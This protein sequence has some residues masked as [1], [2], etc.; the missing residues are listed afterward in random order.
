MP[1]G[2][3]AW[4]SDRTLKRP[5]RRDAPTAS[6]PQSHLWPRVPL[7]RVQEAAV[8][9]WLPTR[10]WL[11]AL[12]VA[13]LLRSLTPAASG[14]AAALLRERV[15][16]ALQRSILQQAVALPLA[17]FERSEVYA[18]LDA[19]RIALQ[20]PVVDVLWDLNMLA[21]SLI[22][23]AGLL[24]LALRGTIDIG[25]LVA[26]LDGISRYRSL[27]WII[28]G[29][30]GR[31]VE[32]WAPVTYLR[33]FLALP[34]GNEGAGAAA[35]HEVNAQQ[36]D[37]ANAQRGH[38]TGWEE[39]IKAGG[40]MPPKLRQVVSCR[41]LSFTY[42]GADRP[43]LANVNLTFGAGE[44]VALVGENGAGKTTLVKVLLG[45][46]QP[47]EGHI[48][49]D[50]IDLSTLDPAVWRRQATAI[51]QD[52]VHYPTTALE[53]IAYA[54]VALLASEQ[55][56]EQAVPV[57]VAAAARQSGADAVIAALTSARSP[58]GRWR[59]AASAT[60]N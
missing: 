9:P 44:H 11:A 27:A 55:F 15:N 5:A 13:T 3:A 1:R 2:S 20:N 28:S 26:L 22:A 24:L 42:P 32:R 10:P 33:E 34:I 58:D 30:I 37:G 51:F 49:V 47:T 38:A 54:D 29:S 39:G 16:A 12:L 4:K 35:G 52:F 23:A 31:L 60:Q 53:N 46:Y 41:Q 18:K 57:P 50:G 19:G 8:D 7:I 45:L 25:S 36:G 48:T 21:T 59:H 14:Y 17:A 43:A 40:G 6:C 56:L